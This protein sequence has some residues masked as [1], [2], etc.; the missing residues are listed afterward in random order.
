MSTHPFIDPQRPRA[1]IKP[2]TAMSRMK[3][4]IADK[5]D[6]EQV[7]HIIEALNGRMTQ[8]NLIQF[9]SAPKG[10]K[11]LAERRYLPPFL[12]DHDWIRALPEGT[13]G[14]AYVD[15][16]E[17]EG[18]TA[19]G[20]VEESEKF[21]SKLSAFD[22]DLTWFINRQRDTHDLF[23]VLSG[24]GRD[25]LGEASLLAFSHGQNP[26]RGILFIAFMASRELQKVLPRQADVMACYREGKRNGAAASRIVEEDILAL[27][28]EPLQAAR[29]RLGIAKPVAYRQALKVCADAGI[30][31]HDINPAAA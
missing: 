15:F 14:R 31:A 22:D 10:A 5:E 29:E 26:S 3:R 6:T 1:R 7:F 18:L 9:A 24:Y 16:M 19:Q 25:A 23:H 27:L 2:L 12:D 13:V 21:R 8:Q 4:L 11:R 30:G 20:L 17:R 28:K